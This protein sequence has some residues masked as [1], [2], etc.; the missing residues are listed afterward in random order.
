MI[1]RIK[2]FGIFRFSNKKNFDF[3]FINSSSI[4]K[5][6]NFF[7]QNVDKNSK[8]PTSFAL[9]FVSLALL[10]A[11]KNRFQHRPCYLKPTVPRLVPSVG[12]GTNPVRNPASFSTLYTKFLSSG[13]NFGKCIFTRWILLVLRTKIF[14]RHPVGYFRHPAAPALTPGPLHGA[15]FVVTATP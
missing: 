1:F 3:F 2:I 8:N 4:S 5:K 11:S 12:I 13:Q 9:G 14:F 7:F 15:P 10:R 6:I